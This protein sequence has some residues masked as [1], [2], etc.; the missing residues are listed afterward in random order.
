MVRDLDDFNERGFSFRPGDDD[1]NASKRTI[2]LRKPAS[3]EHARVQVDDASG[4]FYVTPTTEGFDAFFWS[5]GMVRVSGREF[6]G[7]IESGCA[8]RGDL[9]C[10]SCHSMHQSQPDDQLALGM[11][12]D[13]ACTQCHPAFAGSETALQ[14]HTHHEPES[15]GSR[16]M[17]CHMPYTTYGLLKTIRSHLIDS[18]TI[19]AELASGRPNAC[20]LCHLDRSLE[21]TSALLA[22]WYGQ[23]E[24]GLSEEQRRIAAGLRWLLGG[25]AGQRAIAADAM[26]RADAQDASGRGWTAPHL[27]VLLD[28]SYAALRFIA[29]RSLRTLGEPALAGYDSQ[30]ESDARRRVA[31]QVMFNGHWHDGLASRAPDAGRLIGADG[32]LDSQRID[33]LI[34]ARDNRPMDLRE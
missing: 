5:D 8:E 11:G 19:A 30:D 34:G 28:D 33:A 21:W 17:N 27:A 25:D 13:G 10:L 26:G 9:Q 22:D 15:S 18:P 2:V 7:M 12:G 6:N 23:Q 14:G 16:C 3:G 32:T 29:A 1:L 4:P 24:P 31:A 20:N